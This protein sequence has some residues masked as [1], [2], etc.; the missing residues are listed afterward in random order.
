MAKDLFLQVDLKKDCDDKFIINDETGFGITGFKLE[1]EEDVTRYKLSDIVLYTILVYNKTDEAKVEYIKNETFESEDIIRYKYRY[2]NMVKPKEIEI[3]ID[4]YY[5]LYYIAVPKELS[6]LRQNN[7]YSDLNGNIYT[8]EDVEVSVFDIDFCQSNI[9]YF[10]SDIFSVGNLRRSYLKNVYDKIFKQ[11]DG[12]LNKVKKNCCKDS[13][14]IYKEIT[15]SAL[16]TIQYLIEEC[17]Y[18]EAQIVVEQLSG[19]GDIYKNNKKESTYSDCGC[20]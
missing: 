1:D 8:E 6:I 16:S 5:T 20:K 15:G 10:I 7:Y 18:K 14:D 3:E 12:I 19:C 9:M 13:D 2:T 11:K 17:K 4:G